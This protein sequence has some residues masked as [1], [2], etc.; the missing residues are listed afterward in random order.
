MGAKDKMNSATTRVLVSGN[1]TRVVVTEAA[2]RQGGRDGEED[3]EVGVL[4]PGNGGAALA[5]FLIPLGLFEWFFKSWL[6]TFF[7]WVSP[8]TIVWVMIQVVIIFP[9]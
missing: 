8:M 2:E 1:P 6:L 9:R 5:L 3:E 7:D 4:Q